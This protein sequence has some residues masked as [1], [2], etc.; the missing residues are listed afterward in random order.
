MVYVQFVGSVSFQ[1]RVSSETVAG[2]DLVRGIRYHQQAHC[3][4]YLKPNSSIRFIS[5]QP[6]ILIF[7]FLHIS[8]GVRA[9]EE[10]NFIFWPLQTSK[11]GR[12]K[13]GGS[14]C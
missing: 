3:V 10:G 13:S 8:V 11:I 7:S 14:V 2:N 1:A 9:G 6:D 12:I 4:H 5:N